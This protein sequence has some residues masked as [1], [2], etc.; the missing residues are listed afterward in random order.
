MVL[1]AALTDRSL[2]EGRMLEILR[3]EERLTA[4]FLRLP[5]DYSFWRKGFGHDDYD[6]HD[7]L[8][9][10]SE[11]VKDGLIPITEYLGPSP[12]SKRMID[13][14]NDAWHYA[15]LET[16]FGAI[17]SDDVELNGDQLQSLSRLYWFTGNRKYLDWAI[18][19]GDYYLL[20]SHHPTRNRHEL[21]LRDHGCEFICGLTELYA[22]VSV[23]RPEKKLAYQRPIQVMLDRILEVGRNED[24]FLYNRINPRTGEVIREEGVDIADNWGYTY[25]GF[26]TVYLLDGTARYRVETRK[27]LESLKKPIYHN[28]DWENGSHDGF[29]DSIEGAINLYNFE[30]VRAAA[31]WIDT[32]IQ[33]LWSKQQPDGIIEGWHADGNFARTTIMYCLWKSQGITIQPWRNDVTLGAVRRGDDL[34]VAIKADQ[35]WQG[36]VRFDYP[37]HKAIMHL[38]FNYPRINS[39][40]EWFTVEKDESYRIVEA[41]SGRQNDY[42]GEVMSQGLPVNLEAG[43]ERV[44][45]VS[46]L[47]SHKT[48]SAIPINLKPQITTETLPELN[49]FVNH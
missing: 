37:R 47:S 28:F 2:F 11:Y 39:F 29:S 25:N 24:G 6:L 41:D 38:P 27:V 7:I 12:W 33:I 32:E 20:G 16:P 15:Q 34:L 13:L 1:T 36:T 23:A 40:P 45:R 31:D 30:P 49:P 4:R 46:P 21:K 26:Y 48:K 22:T 19:L 5:D 3:A 44:W 17:L 9:G 18:R 42:S 35:P 43:A 8:F 10:A 14:T